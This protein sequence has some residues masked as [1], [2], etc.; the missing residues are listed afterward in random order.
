MC[1][2]IT[3]NLRSRYFEIFFA[4]IV[5]LAMLLNESF[6]LERLKTK[7]AD[8][9]EVN[10]MLFIRMSQI[11]TK[12][13]NTDLFLDQRSEWVRSKNEKLLNAVEKIDVILSLHQKSIDSIIEIDKQFKD[14]INS[15]IYSAYYDTNVFI[16]LLSRTNYMSNV[17]TNE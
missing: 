5:V 6:R 15:T 10:K 13:Q 1:D 7:L 3:C 17:H 12:I 11:E 4:F 16:G 14:H 2:K 9:Q 8:Q